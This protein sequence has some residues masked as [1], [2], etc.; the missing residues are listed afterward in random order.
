MTALSYVTRANL[1]VR[2]NIGTAD[3]TDDDLLDD[4]CS[5]VNAYVEFVTHRPVGPTTGGTA[6]FD[7]QEDV[8]PGGRL[9]VRQG[10]RTVTSATVAPGTGETAVEANVA[11]IIVLPRSQNRRPDWP[12]DWL[13]FK[14]VVVG[15]VCDWGSGY[16]G[17]TIVG[18]LGWASIPPEVSEVAEILA[19]RAWYARQAG[20]ADLVGS[21]ETGQPLVSRFLSARD[22]DTLKAYRPD[23]L[24]VG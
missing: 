6:I 4:L 18:D 11:D 10:I 9:Y 7:A 15:D 24:A 13:I 19:T 2:L 5:Q 3:T 8:Y 20:Q 14:D 17:I 16:G 22:R 23:R 21:D 12:G 1:K